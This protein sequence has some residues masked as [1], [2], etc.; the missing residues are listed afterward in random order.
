MCLSA[1]TTM[2]RV[3]YQQNQMVKKEKQYN[4]LSFPPFHDDFFDIWANY[5]TST[6]VPTDKAYSDSLLPS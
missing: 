1:L 3:T 6:T 4:T 2:V 5:I